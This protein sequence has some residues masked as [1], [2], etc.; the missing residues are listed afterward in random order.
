MWKYLIINYLWFS[1]LFFVHF[2]GSRMDQLA[3]LGMMLAIA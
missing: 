3:V 2:F 1:I